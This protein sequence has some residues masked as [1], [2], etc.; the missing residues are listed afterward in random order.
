MSAGSCAESVAYWPAG[1]SRALWA[2]AR[3][4]VI[5]SCGRPSI[6]TVRCFVKSLAPVPA[7][8]AISKHHKANLEPRK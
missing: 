2:A 8:A 7:K 1:V 6:F 3:R 5:A 4:S